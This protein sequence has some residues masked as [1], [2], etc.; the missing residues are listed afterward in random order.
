MMAAGLLPKIRASWP[1]RDRRARVLLGAVVIVGALFNAAVGLFSLLTPAAFLAAVGQT[2]PVV[3]P[4][5]SVFA[6]Y[7][8]ARELAIAVGLI[9]GAALRMAPA[10]LVVLAPLGGFGRRTRFSDAC[11][12]ARHL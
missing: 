6:E 3:T 7:A 12:T 4:S 11:Q 10:L 8:G 9:V 5:T 2:T 1:T